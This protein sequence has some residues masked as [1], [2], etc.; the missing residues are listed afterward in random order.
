M[1][2]GTADSM[3]AGSKVKPQAWRWMSYL[4]SEACQRTVAET[5]IVFPARLSLAGLTLQAHRAQG[6]D[7]SAFVQAAKGHTVLPPILD[8]SARIDDI[9]KSAMESVHLGKMSAAQALKSVDDQIAKRGSQAD[10]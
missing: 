6:V 1:L 7:S 3:W 4:A 9:V 5:G 2:N 10:R 8:D